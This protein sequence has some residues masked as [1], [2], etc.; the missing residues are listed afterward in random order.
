M[1]NKTV[2]I[3]EDDTIIAL[4]IKRMLNKTGVTRIS[5]FRDPD[6]LYTSSLSNHPDLII[7]EILLKNNADT[8]DYFDTLCS[9][10]HIPMIFI[11]AGNLEDY[12]KRLHCSHCHFIPKPFDDDSLV[13]LLQ[14]LFRDAVFN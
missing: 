9:N 8:L 6:S 5:I 3:A 1:K 2:Y 7:T 12:S 10:Y 13:V 14:D 11:T 4:D